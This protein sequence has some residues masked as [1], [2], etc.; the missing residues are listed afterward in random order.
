MIADYFAQRAVTL[1]ITDDSH[2]PKSTSKHEHY[3]VV[4]GGDTLMMA[5]LKLWTVKNRPDL[6]L[7]LVYCD[8]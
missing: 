7:R 8:R 3:E 4:T 2:L 6:K 1:F 5:I